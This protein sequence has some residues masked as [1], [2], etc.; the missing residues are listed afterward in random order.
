MPF[1]HDD[2]VLQEVHGLLPL[3]PRRRQRGEKK[4]DDPRKNRW[5][6]YL[7]PQRPRQ[8][9]IESPD[10]KPTKTP[11]IILILQVSCYLVTKIGEVK[12]WIS[13][14]KQMKTKR[15]CKSHHQQKVLPHSIHYTWTYFDLS[16]QL[17]IHDDL[18]SQKW[19]SQGRGP[20]TTDISISH[21][22][23]KVLSLG[24]PK[25]YA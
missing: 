24:K 19:S 14:I 25:K 17:G 9:P 11:Q 7:S 20:V 6:R 1:L 13:E 12:N 4:R 5:R 2:C 10:K 3:D 16:K 18:N 8:L 23:G 15:K 22:I 21:H